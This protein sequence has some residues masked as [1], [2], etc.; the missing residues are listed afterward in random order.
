MN[1]IDEAPD[2]GF[3]PRVYESP[4]E[5]LHALVREGRGPTIV[6]LHGAASNALAFL[7]ILEAFA[8]RRLVCVDLPGHGASPP[9]EDWTLARLAARIERSIAAEEGEGLVWGGHSWGGKLAAAIAGTRP[10]AVRGLVLVDPSP[11][12]PIPISA[13]AFLVS[14]LQPEI[15]PW[16]SM[17]DAIATVRRLPQYAHWR[18]EIERCFRRG[19]RRRAD[20]SVAGRARLDWLLAISRATL[21]HDE[22]PLVSQIEC[23]SLLI[24]AEE[25][26]AW[27]R[28]T[29][30]VAFAALPR[31]EEVTLPGQHWLMFEPPEPLVRVIGTWLDETIEA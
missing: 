25:S 12:T 18:P 10:R 24:F 11:A 8:D 28:A 30:G 13:E 27:Q 6:L 31:V 9:T 1:D 22:S 21:L 20:G 3:Q 14:A 19:V 26:L 16:A 29:N 17:D 2:L 23:P 5:P 4:D 7:P 15:G